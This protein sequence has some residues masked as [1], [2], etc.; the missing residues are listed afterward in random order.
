MLCSDT[1][2]T[3]KF[4]RIDFKVRYERERIFNSVITVSSFSKTSYKQDY[5][6]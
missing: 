3:K 2:V 1:F 4:V 6:F 5:A